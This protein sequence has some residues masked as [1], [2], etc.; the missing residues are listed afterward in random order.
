MDC[1]I[2]MLDSIFD[3]IGILDSMFDLIDA[4]DSIE[5]I[6]LIEVFDSIQILDSSSLNFQIRHF[7]GSPVPYPYLQI[8]QDFG[9]ASRRLFPVFGLAFVLFPICQRLREY[10]HQNHLQSRLFLEQALCFDIEPDSIGL[11]GNDHSDSIDSDLIESDSMESDSNDS[12]SS[13][14]DSTGLCLFC[15]DSIDSDSIDFDSVDFDSVE[16]DSIES[17]LIVSSSIESDSDPIPPSHSV[18]DLEAN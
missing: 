15:S 3:S 12:D 5:V 2:E 6:D 14:S 11:I 13:Y 10:H 17:D 8:Y 16:S 9:H 4:L 18:S 7:P 1:L